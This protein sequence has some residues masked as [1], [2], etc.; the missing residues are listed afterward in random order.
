MN[1]S[2]D[3][4][5][6][7][8]E[9]DRLG[10]ASFSKQVGRAIYEYKGKDSLVIGLFGKWGTGK[11]SVANMALQTVKE[12]AQKDTKPPII[13]RFAPWNYSDKDNLIGQ[14]LSTL[15]TNIDTGDDELKK[16]VGKALADYSGVFDFASLIPFVGGPL[17]TLLKAIART[18]G[19]EL[20]KPQDLYSSK[21]KLEEALIEVNQKIIVLIDDIDRLTNPQIRDIFQLVKQ[22]GDLPNITYILVM[23]RDVVKRALS[24][25]HNY[26][27]NEYLEKIIQIPFEIPELRKSKLHDIFFSRL[28]EIIREISS[29][30]TWDQ[31]YFTKVFNNCVD[32]YI[33]TLR[34]VNRVLN[35]FQF[36]FSMLYEETSIEDMLGITTLEV[37]CPELYKWIADNKDAVCGGLFHELRTGKEK[38]E[39]NKKKYV[40]EFESVGLEPEQSIMAVAAMF[41]VFAN[42]VN[43]CFYEYSNENNIRMQMRAAHSE[44]FELYFMFDTDDVKVPRNVI[45]G[46]IYSL[47]R[48][49]LERV[50]FEINSQGNIMYFIEE[51]KSMV[52]KIPYERLSILATLFMEMRNGFSGR[53]S[54][55]F[56]MLSPKTAAG[57]LSEMIM[58]KLNTDEERYSIYNE[59][60][61]SATMDSIGSMAY[62]IRKLELAYGRFTNA[63]ENKEDQL[64]SLDQLKDLENVFLKKLDDFS[65]VDTL[66]D[67][68]YSTSTL[69]LWEDLDQEKAQNYIKRV[70][71]NPIRKLKYICKLA[72]KWN[73]GT[74][75]GWSFEH[76]DYSKFA[77]TEEIFNSIKE[78]DK[79]KLEEFNKEEQVKLASFYLNYNKDEFQH[80]TE[81]Q[82]ME[83]VKR[84]RNSCK[85]DS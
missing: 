54:Q 82:A 23:D 45:N 19:E 1:Y 13:I 8:L 52:D 67:H 3:R 49:E 36:R 62:E 57:Y 47:D 17:A 12:L 9:E 81:Q 6:E 43:A 53:S 22:V 34:D 61:M 15:K 80:V 27:G 40:A 26:D 65:K 75:S 14:F 25:V 64:I 55:D 46:C 74:G 66:L 18:G 33:I 51:V 21:K 42:D 69:Y 73:G 20:S 41:P 37:M 83:L 16:K 28:N 63:P 60:L 31:R 48:K 10:R 4:A 71:T 50:V 68:E 58:R 30:V 11:T 39:E 24:D 72:G 70:F 35:T 76:S 38:T 32:P 7:Y 56:F 79:S 2:T 44:R 84:W 85:T 5:I 78:L 77:T 29:E 59:S